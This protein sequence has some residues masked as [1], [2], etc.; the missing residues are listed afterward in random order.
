MTKTPIKKP[1]VI[2]VAAQ[3]AVCGAVAAFL[4]SF[5]FL[6]VDVTPAIH[7]GAVDVT[8]YLIVVASTAAGGLLGFAG[9][10][11]LGSAVWFI[12]RMEARPT[13]PRRW[14][15]GGDRP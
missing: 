6:F 14:P 7:L 12:E 5:M 11:L 1:A 9:A 2:R 8:Q 4:N 15:E 3:V 13:V 10:L